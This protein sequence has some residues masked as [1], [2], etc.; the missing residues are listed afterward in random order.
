[1]LVTKNLWKSLA[2]DSAHAGILSHGFQETCRIRGCAV[3]GEFTPIKL[4]VAH[5]RRRAARIDERNVVEPA[6]P[7]GAPIK[8]YR[9]VFEFFVRMRRH[10]S[11]P[12]VRPRRLTVR[13][14]SDKRKG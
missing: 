14:D 8:I 9:F 7:K 11:I 4:T 6:A 12:F 2:N 10:C 5:G 3:K 1:M 13:T